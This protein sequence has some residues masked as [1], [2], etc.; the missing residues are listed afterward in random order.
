MRTSDTA[1][2]TIT[3]PPV[4]AD[5]ACAQRGDLTRTQTGVRGNMTSRSYDPGMAS[6]SV[7]TCSAVRKYISC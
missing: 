3:R 5:M 1:V 4:Q 2:T 7:A 6:A